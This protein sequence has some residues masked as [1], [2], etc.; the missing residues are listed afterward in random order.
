MRGQV[1]NAL[2]GAAV[3]RALVNVNGRQVLTDSQGH[4]EFPQYADQQGSLT[5]TKPGYS[6][7]PDGAEGVVQRKIADLDSPIEVKLYPNGLITG[8]VTGSDGLPVSQVQVSLRKAVYDPQGMHWMNTGFSMTNSEGEFR[9]RTPAGQF[10][11]G[12]GFSPRTRETGEALLPVSFPEGSS[13]EL[14]GSFTL[15]PGEEKHVDLRPRMGPAFPFMVRVDH[16]EAR[17]NV[18]FSVLTGNGDTFSTGVTN[19]ST[20]G[21]YRLQL[22]SG[23]YTLRAH[24]DARDEALDGSARVTVTAAA[25]QEVAIHLTPAP[26]LPIEV[27][28]D[29]LSTTQPGGNGLQ[30]NPVSSA[31]VNPQQL[32]LRLRNFAG[33][34]DGMNQDLPMHQRED[35]SF[36]FRPAPGRYRLEGGTGGQWYVESATYG[37]TN[38]LTSD[39]VISPGSAGAPIRVVVGNVKGTVQGHVSLPVGM[40]NAWVYLLPRQPSLV[41][42]TF[43]LTNTDGS[44][45]SQLPAGE[46]FAVAVPRRLQEDLRDGEVIKRLESAGKTLEVTANADA[47]IDLEVT[48]GT[49]VT[50]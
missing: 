25:G 44:F 5:V 16:G 46:Y 43:L 17:S 6:Q 31:T 39:I 35:K 13:S 4:F 49:G 8:V 26:F 14:G 28:Q 41:P 1:L 30:V 19:G 15:L 10:R 48:Q 11:I 37:T 24:L 27:A 32:N 42:A 3:P 20:P 45:S 29:P 21:E 40:T 33:V 50:P 2:T 22:P 38:L 34:T 47:P 9:F 18:R 12:V 7:D 36:E 23:T